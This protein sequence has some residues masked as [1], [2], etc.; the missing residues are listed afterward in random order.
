MMR[1]STRFEFSN[2]KNSLKL[3][4]RRIVS[5]ESSPY[6]LDGKQPFGRRF[7]APIG[8]VIVRVFQVG[9][10]ECASIHVVRL[11]RVHTYMV[12]CFRPD[13]PRVCRK[14]GISG[15]V[16]CLLSPVSCLLSSASWQYNKG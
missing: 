14:R 15:T 7:R 5:I 4:G 10:G 12:A 11:L 13:C 2:L 1:Y 8:N 3:G 16:T 9:H 6:Q